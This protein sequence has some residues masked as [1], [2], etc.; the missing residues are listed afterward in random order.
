MLYVYQMITL[1]LIDLQDLRNVTF[2]VHRLFETFSWTHGT[3]TRQRL[4]GIHTCESTGRLIIQQ[5]TRLQVCLPSI[6]F[7]L[8]NQFPTIAVLNI[9]IFSLLCNIQQHYVFSSLMISSSESIAC[10]YCTPYAKKLRRRHGANTLHD[11]GNFC[12]FD[13]L[14]YTCLAFRTRVYKSNDT[15]K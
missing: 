14:L 3:D 15:F 9:R 11:V 10:Y 8:S 4:R 2:I 5:W 13:Q 6:V 7:S 12:L 1:S